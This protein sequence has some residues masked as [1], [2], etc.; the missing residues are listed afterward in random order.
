M[1]NARWLVPAALAAALAGATPSAAATPTFDPRGLATPPLR[2]LKA[3]QPERWTLP[4]GVTVFLL[5]DHSLPVVK[6]TAYLPSSPALVPAD[7]VGLAQVTG[8]SMR[9]GGTARHP[10]DALDDRLG[11]IGASVT[12]SVSAVL[13]QGGFRCLSENT[14]EV[15]DAFADVLRRPVFPD[16]KIELARVALRQEIASRNDEMIPLLLRVAQQAVYGKDSPWA[17]TPEYVTVESITRDDCARLHGRVFVPERLVLAVYGDFRAA[18]MK[19]LLKASFGDWKRS[20]TPAPALPPPPAAPAPRLVFAPKDDVTQTGIVLAQLG[21]RADDPDYAAMQVF[22]Q[23]LGGGFASRLVDR[24]RS[25]RGLAYTAGAS[26]GADFTRPG[27]FAA[28]TLT[29]NDSAMTALQLLRDQ[30]AL[31][32]REPFTSAEFEVAVGAVR[33][34]FVFNFEDPSQVLFRAAYYQVTGYPL[35]FLQRY[36]RA[37]DAVTV[38]S[39]LEAARRKVDPGALVAVMVGKEREFERPLDSAGLQVERA[40]IAIP[41]P[42]SSLAV[43]EAT[44]QALAQGRAWLERAAQAAGGTAAWEKVKAVSVEQSMKVTMQGQT[45][46]ITSTGLWAFPDRQRVTQK[47]PMM[48]LVQ[49]FDGSVGWMS[50]MGQIQD[51]PRMASEV[52][53]EWERSFFRLFGRPAEVRLQALPEPQTVDGVRCDVA[54][55]RSELV[56]DWTVYFGPDGLIARMEY[57]DEGPQGAPARITQTFGDWRPQGPLRYPHASRMLVDG[58][59]FVEASVVSVTLDPRIP[60]GAFEKPRP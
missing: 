34:A 25:Q 60:E 16:D 15:I 9:S 21:H 50:A 48:E 41:P 46:D 30:V 24:I 18:D 51:Q 17:R 12:T 27:V 59:P 5:E 26:A 3:V 42:P 23:A 49:G 36:Q 22:E 29:R 44:P 28:Y 58:K 31:A 6:G 35:D 33:N 45:L 7:R 38:G 54:V 4:N 10:G 2:S 1:R 13:A 47:L 20:G 32:V 53:E 52:R 43:G 40:D 8:E 11:A 55:V 14:A 19:R 37:L 56:R 57:A 39:V